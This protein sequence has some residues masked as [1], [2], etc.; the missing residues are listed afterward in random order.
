MSSSY[1]LVYHSLN[2]IAGS[3]EQVAAEINQILAVSR[4]N[5]E[6]V[7]VTGALMF[8]SGYFAQVLEGSQGAIEATFERIQRDER[9]GEVTLLEFAPVEGRG[10]SNW[11]MAFVGSSAAENARFGDL[12]ASTG[13]DP[14]RLSGEALFRRIRDV[15]VSEDSAAA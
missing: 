11:S 9:H 1:R 10:F 5:N 2:R 13:F 7:G 14:N 12:A 6:K 3:D 15:L 4:T 8:N